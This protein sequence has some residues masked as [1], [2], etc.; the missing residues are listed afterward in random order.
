MKVFQIALM[1]LFFVFASCKKKK[2]FDS[3]EWKDESLKITAQLCEKYRTCADDHWP[4]I[5][6][7]LKEFSKSRLDEANCQKE[8]RESNVYKLI[9]A[10]PTLIMS[11]YRNCHQKILKE[12]CESLRK[13]YI[14]TLEDCNAIKKIQTGT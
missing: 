12:S 14:D 8:F 5:P 2:G 6:E 9:G 13:G 3:V 1:I 10:D 7:K 4:G 11:M